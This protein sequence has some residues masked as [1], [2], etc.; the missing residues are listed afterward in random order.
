MISLYSEL[1]K[2]L[3]KSAFFY[4]ANLVQIKLAKNSFKHE[5]E[6]H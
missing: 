6:H 5:E 3:I 4:D 1:K 2:A